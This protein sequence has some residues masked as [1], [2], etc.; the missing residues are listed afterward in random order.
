MILRYW[1]LNIVYLI[2]I[3][4]LVPFWSAIGFVLTCSLLFWL[5]VPSFQCR[6]C[7]YA[8]KG[9]F[10]RCGMHPLAF[11]LW[12]VSSTT[13]FSKFISKVAMFY[14]CGAPC[15][16]MFIFHGVSYGTLL[17]FAG[18]FWFICLTCLICPWCKNTHCWIKQ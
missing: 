10:L 12:R 15:I 1:L 8:G 17:G 2:I 14:W 13:K 16:Y 9:V 3:F 6:N 18:F 5:I 4:L 7:P 11:R